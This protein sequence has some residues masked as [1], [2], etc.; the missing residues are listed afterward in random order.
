MVCACTRNCDAYEKLLLARTRCKVIFFKKSTKCYINIICY[1]TYIYT[2]IYIWQQGARK[3]AKTQQ[4]FSL[5]T[6]QN[7]LKGSGK[8][9]YDCFWPEALIPVKPWPVY[10]A[11]FFRSAMIV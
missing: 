5:Q 7:M 10:I 11:S 6:W 2:N 4:V 3:E 1:I 8:E 9:V